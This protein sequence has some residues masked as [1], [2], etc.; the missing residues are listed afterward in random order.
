[1]KNGKKALSERPKRVLLPTDFENEFGNRYTLPKELKAHLTSK[2]FEWR[3]V[4]RKK[5]IENGGYH[6]RGWVAYHKKQHGWPEGLNSE[7]QVGSDPNEN[8]PRGTDILAVRRIET[9][10]K[11]RAFLAQRR[12]QYKK[13]RQEC[14]E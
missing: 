5:L 6:E 3:F 11:H 4:S 8:Y 9:G 12:E 7:F 13:P 2:G 10:D 14:C 1:M